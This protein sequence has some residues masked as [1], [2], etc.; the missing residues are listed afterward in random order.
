MKAARVSRP[1]HTEPPGVTGRWP[2]TAV[3]E[4]LGRLGPS[5]L[6]DGVPATER[7]VRFLRRMSTAM[8]SQ[9]VF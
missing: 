4:M 9:H 7:C 8:A 1:P 3:P 5:P 6:P 2:G